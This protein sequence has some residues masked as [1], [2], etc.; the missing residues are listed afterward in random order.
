MNV[1]SLASRL[2][3]APCA[4][5]RQGAALT[6]GQ[7]AGRESLVP[8]PLLRLLRLLG[9]GGAAGS[10]PNV[11][12]APRLASLVSG[13]PSCLRGGG[14]LAGAWT[15]RAGGRVAK[16]VSKGK[17]AVRGCLHPMSRLPAAAAN[18]AACR[19]SHRIL[20]PLGLRWC[21]AVVWP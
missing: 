13:A 11:A 5:P 20:H 14:H 17:Q 19:C 10:A 4:H 3:S 6:P 9:L 16:A 21:F 7:L 12:V 8:P 15:A 18:A 2:H 1:D